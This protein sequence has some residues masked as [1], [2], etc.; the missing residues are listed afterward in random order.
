MVNNFPAHRKNIEDL[1]WKSGKTLP[2]V[3]NTMEDN[4]GFLARYILP[5][6]LSG[7]RTLGLDK[8]RQERGIDYDAP[9]QAPTPYRGKQDDGV[10]P[11]RQARVS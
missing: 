3:M 6:F 8:E 1:Y 11:A 10:H 5:L 4:Y 7:G 9:D 2:E